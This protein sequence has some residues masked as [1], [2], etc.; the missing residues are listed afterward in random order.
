MENLINKEHIKF[1]SPEEMLDYICG[2]N[3]LYNLETGD[4]IWKYTECGSI[5]VDNFNLEEA[6]EIEKKA[7]EIDEY[8]GGFIGGGSI[9]YDDPSHELYE[10]HDASNLDYC[11]EVYDKGTWIDVSH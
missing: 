2:D 9:I 7:N 4:Y 5:A 10:E 8:W 3:D 11:K 1:D 6:E